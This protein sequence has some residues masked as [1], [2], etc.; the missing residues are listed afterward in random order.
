[1]ERSAAVER[2]VMSD[3]TVLGEKSRNKARERFP[4]SLP[5]YLRQRCLC[6]G[7]PEGHLHTSIHLDRCRQLRTSLL[8]QAR[9]GIQPTEAPVAMGLERAHPQRLGEGEGLAVVGGGLVDV[10]RLV[11]P[12]DLAEEPI[13]VC[14]IASSGVGTG[15]IEEVAGEEARVLHTADEQQSI[16]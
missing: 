11:M 4:G 8:P 13:G 5:F 1:M 16:A 7:E 12:G 6:L 2:R 3:V 14:L 9:R 10:R 15:E